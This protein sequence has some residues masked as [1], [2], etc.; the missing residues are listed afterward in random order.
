MFARAVHNADVVQ[1]FHFLV[2]PMAG[3]YVLERAVG[4]PALE[5]RILAV[6][7]AVEHGCGFRASHGRVRTDAFVRVADDI[8]QV[9]VRVDVLDALR[10]IDVGVILDLLRRLFFMRDTIGFRRGDLLA[11]FRVKE[12]G[13]DLGQ[14]AFRCG[15]AAEG[16]ADTASSSASPIEVT[17]LKRFSKM[18]F[19]HPFLFYFCCPIGLTIRISI[20]L[21]R[22]AAVSPPFQKF[23]YIEKTA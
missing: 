11:V 18:P 15:E 2:E 6:V 8:G 9:L 13:R 10:V 4:H 19:S 14:C 16:N 1:R 17:R 20:L 12:L 21:R 7:Q 5:R 22:S 3:L 23:C